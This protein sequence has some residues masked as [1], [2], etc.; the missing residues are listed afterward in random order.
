MKISIIVV[1]IF[2]C[3]FLNCKSADPQPQPVVEKPE[4]DFSQS[5]FYT[6]QDIYNSKTQT[7]CSM[8]KPYWEGKIL[9]VQGFVYDVATNKGSFTLFSDFNYSAA[10]VRGLFLRI[11]PADSTAIYEKLAKNM[12]KGN[13]CFIKATGQTGQTNVSNCQFS[14]VS[15]LMSANDVE[16]Q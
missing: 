8:T 15:M 6:I 14:F 10:D 11:N 2:C 13:R 1:L 16:F 12:G 5:K 4:L 9:K 7:P 3:G